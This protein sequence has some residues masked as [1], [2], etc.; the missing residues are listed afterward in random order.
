MSV[1]QTICKLLVQAPCLTVMGLPVLVVSQGADVVLVV[2]ARLNWQLH[3]GEAPKWAS[4]VKF[5][6]LDIAP[7]QRDTQISQVRRMTMQQQ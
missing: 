1:V 2:G 5:I 3:F 6:L 7:S 4:G